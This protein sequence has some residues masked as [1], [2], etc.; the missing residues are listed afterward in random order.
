MRRAW[1]V[2]SRATEASVSSIVCLWSRARVVLVRGPRPPPAPRPR[3]DPGAALGPE[4]R[5]SFPRGRTGDGIGAISRE[6]R[7]LARLRE[8]R[9]MCLR[10]LRVPRGKRQMRVRCS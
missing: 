6:V 10:R 9:E 1:R 3:P 4:P 7:T 8:V 5:E 2:S